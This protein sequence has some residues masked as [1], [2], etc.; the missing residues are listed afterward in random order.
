MINEAA[1][2]K[3]GGIFGATPRLWRSTRPPIY[4]PLHANPLRLV[5]ALYIRRPTRFRSTK[6]LGLGKDTDRSRLTGE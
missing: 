3:D 5:M 1:F 2:F 4:T 6:L